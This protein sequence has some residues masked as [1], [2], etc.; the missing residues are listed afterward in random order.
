MT[1]DTQNIHQNNTIQT[2]NKCV[3]SA[4]LENVSKCHISQTVMSQM[5]SMNDEAYA[6]IVALVCA[7]QHFFTIDN[8]LLYML[9]IIQRN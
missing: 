9:S 2:G 5:F 7:G 3:T 8:Y 4:N 6:G 1:A